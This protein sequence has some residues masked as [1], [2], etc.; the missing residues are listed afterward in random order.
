VI[1][2]VRSAVAHGVLSAA[3]VAV[4]LLVK[5]CLRIAPVRTLRVAASGNRHE[6]PRACPSTVARLAATVDSLAWTPLLMSDC[7]SR[8]LTV[9]VLASFAGSRPVFVI[10]ARRRNGGVQA[11]AWLE[12]RGVVIA[13]EEEASYARLWVAS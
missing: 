13:R 3:A 6:T 8:A 4:L 7:L 2:R 11:H 1:E 10:G 12:C 9:L 5:L